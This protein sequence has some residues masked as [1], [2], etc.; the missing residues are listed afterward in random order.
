MGRRK[1]INFGIGGLETPIPESVSGTEPVTKVTGLVSV[2]NK[3]P[4]SV[5][6]EY[7]G[8][9]YV[10]SPFPARGL[11]RVYESKLKKPLPQNVII[12]K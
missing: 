8:E 7:N 2:I 1:K 10:L 12:K 4:Y 3:N 11:E 9:T 6:V 5:M